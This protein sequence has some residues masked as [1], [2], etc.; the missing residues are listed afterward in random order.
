MNSIQP[1]A[2][3]EYFKEMYPD[4]RDFDCDDDVELDDDTLREMNNELEGKYD[5][6]PTSRWGSNE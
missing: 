5:P 6:P 1:G 3:R 2:M 4:E